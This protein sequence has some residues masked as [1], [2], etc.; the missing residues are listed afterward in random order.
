MRCRVLAYMAFRHLVTGYVEDSLE[1][2]SFQSNLHTLRKVFE[3]EEQ[4][5][6]HQHPKPK[7]ANYL[8]SEVPHDTDLIIDKHFEA[9][10]LS[11]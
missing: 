9:R 4:L 3:A 2:S 5:T 7:V 10:R 8:L 1:R 6:D 11:I